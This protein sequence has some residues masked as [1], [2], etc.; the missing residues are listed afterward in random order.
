MVGA[1][2]GGPAQYVER[3]DA[4]LLDVELELGRIV[5]VRDE[6]DAV[7]VADDDAAEDTNG[8]AIEVLPRSSSV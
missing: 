6:G 1:V 3:R 8:E 5:A 7:V 4:D 2:H